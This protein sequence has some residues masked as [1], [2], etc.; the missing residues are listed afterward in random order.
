M[1]IID[2]K[3]AQELVKLISKETNQNAHIFGEGGMIIAT[4]QPE[5]LGTIHSGAKDI[6][7]GKI[8]YIAIT[9]EMAQTMSGTRPGFSIGI[10]S[11][12]KRIGAIGISGDPQ[13]MK[14]IAMI[15][16]HVIALEYE[17]KQFMDNLNN[18]ACEINESLQQSSAG[19]EEISASSDHQVSS[20][21]SLNSMIL[22]ARNQV[23]ETNQIIDFIQK[24]SKQT[25]ILGINASIEA[26]R[27]GND[28]RG[29]NI[30]AN[31]VRKLAVST[32]TS[33]SKVDE[34]LKNIQNL[35][36]TISDNINVYT[37][38]SKE[39]AQVVQSLAYELE[40]ITGSLDNFNQLLTNKEV[41]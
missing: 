41:S 8:D 12:N 9:E 23:M 20:I 24:I 27:L 30:V 32:A 19:L 38:T 1:N 17:R 28:G 31:E 37:T 36:V 18:M 25:N 15:A 11:N 2:A 5:R 14:P 10:N 3:F 33:V 7:A 39:Q 34:V 40:K 6:M 16:S 22:D 21:E 35:I 29:F 13:Q 26:A 4:S